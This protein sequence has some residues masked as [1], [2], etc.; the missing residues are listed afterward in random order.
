MNQVYPFP[1]CRCGFCCLSETCPVGQATYGVGKHDLCPGLSFQGQ[2]ATCAIALTNPEI[3]GVGAGCCIKAR[4]IRGG[5][6]YNFASLPIWL[7]KGIVAN[8]RKRGIAP[9]Y[10]RSA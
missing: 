5:V 4:A 10:R 1:C 9:D 7:K 6:A 3:I 2:K 8:Y